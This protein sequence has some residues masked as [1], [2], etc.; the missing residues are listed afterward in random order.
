MQQQ[1]CQKLLADFRTI[2]CTLFANFDH[3]FR[4]S[5]SYKY[6]SHIKVG[7]L[8]LYSL[9]AGQIYFA[10]VSGIS[11]YRQDTNSSRTRL[12]RRRVLAAIC[13]LGFFFPLFSV[14]QIH[15]G[16]VQFTCLLSG[17]AYCVA[18][19]LIDRSHSGGKKGDTCDE[20]RRRRRDMVVCE[21]LGVSSGKGE[22]KW[23]KRELRLPRSKRISMCARARAYVWTNV[24][25]R[26]GKA[27]EG[28]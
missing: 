5:I 24:S 20:R 23:E 13:V 27:M 18:G 9:Y 25:W 6:W 2:F 19:P 22:E 12:S 16:Y 14:A 28:D 11:K 10:W 26:D 21:K 8:F 1:I 17:Q 4:T 3:F 7:N 15:T